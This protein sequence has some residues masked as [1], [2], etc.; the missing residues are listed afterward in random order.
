MH[1]TKNNDQP[2]P[3]Q[4]LFAVGEVL[5]TAL[6]WSSSFV[7]V[8]AALEYTGPL[9]VA[10]LRYFLAFLF[11]IPWLCNHPQASSSIT[12]LPW[13]RFTLMGLTQYTI[14]NGALFIA[15]KSMP[16]T[17]G[18]LALCLSPL[19]VLLLGILR[20]KEHPTVIQLV[21]LTITLL[22]S[23]LFFSSGLELGDPL[24]FGFLMIAVLSFSV[25]PVLAR[26]V[27]RNRQI[28]NVTL[29]AFPLGIGGVILLLVAGLLEG[30]P[31]MP[32]FVWGI[33]LGLA[34][35]NTL[36]AYLLFNH[37]LQRLTAVQAN[38]M[39]NLSPLGTAIIAWGTLGERLSP[40]Q[41]AAMLLVIAGASLVQQLQSVPRS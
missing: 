7:G 22:G 13:G 23:M 2:W 20:L 30:I 12:R 37:S 9:T 41:V 21:G 10:G 36:L 5:L 27:A 39:L 3:R 33:I 11:L 40:L 28:A 32:V 24:P 15:L 8:K 31:R 18:S 19:P 29:T 26:E 1:C 38:I 4:H 6:I 25:F 16:A 14:G 34:V 35:V 17:T